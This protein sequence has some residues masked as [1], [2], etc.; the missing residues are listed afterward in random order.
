MR[1]RGRHPA[2]APDPDLIRSLAKLL[3]ETGL[4]E[5]EC[6]AGDQHI[7]VSK[8]A[9]TRTVTVGTSPAVEKPVP[10]P[11]SPAGTNGAGH[12]GA[13]GHDHPGTL[14]APLVGIA[15]LAAEPGATPYV[16]I[17]DTVAEGQ[18]LMIIEAMKVMNQ[19]RAPHAGRISRVYVSDAE[20][21]E[22]GT[23]LMLIE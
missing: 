13:N 5:I 2:L 12:P 18:T 15:Y 17:G 23:A 7:R 19:I 1:F 22:Y 16:K 11:P 21:V 8:Q 20:P 6:A 10:A 9:S 3:E 14:K 4:T